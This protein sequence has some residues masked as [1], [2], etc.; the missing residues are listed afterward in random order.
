M[1]AKTV[2]ILIPTEYARLFDRDWRTM[3]IYGGR[4]SL[5]SHTVARALLIRAMTEKTRVL[6]ARELQTSIAD[7]SHKLLAD[8]IAEYGW[9]DFTVQK[10]AIYHKNGSEFV[11]KGLRN[12]TQNIKSLEG[13]DIAWVDEAQM[14]SKSSID[15]LTPTIRKPGSQIIWTMNRLNELDPVYAEYALKPRDDCVVLELNYDVA[16]KYGWLPKVIKD[17]IEYDK[18]HSPELYSHKWLGLPMNQVDNAIISREAVLDAM[19]RN[20]EAE[21]ARE[22]GVDVARMGNDRTELV[23]RQ[24]LKEIARETYTKLRTTEVAEKVM[25]MA[26]GNKDILIKVDDTGVGGGVTDELK[27]QGYNVMAINFGSSAMDK[28]KYT[29]YISEAWFHMAENMPEIQLTTDNELLMELSNRA[30]K[31]DAK[32]RRAVESKDDYKKRGFRSP[33]KADATILCFYT[34]Q[35]PVAEAPRTIF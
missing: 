6:A 2:E 14:I 19:N 13:I 4:Y 33:D 35:I 21:G 3:L 18:E 17:E 15:I 9:T 23:M 30:W 24:G 16:D 28:N 29:N 10:D 34:P 1:N 11:F 26:G 7:S 25:L 22:I 8:L 5:K 31:M 12:N 20:I 27:K 32:G